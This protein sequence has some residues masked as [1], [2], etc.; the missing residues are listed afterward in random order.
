MSSKFDSD[1]EVL[2]AGS[3]SEDEVNDA[4]SSDIYK[5]NGLSIKEFTTVSQ[6]NVLT[7]N[8]QLFNETAFYLQNAMGPIVEATKFA[9]SFP[10]GASR[11]LYSKHP[12]FN[13]TIQ[14]HSEKMLSII[15]KV[16]KQIKKNIQR[17]DNDE[18]LEMML[19]CND[20][21]LERVNSHLD[22]LAGIRVNPETILIE[23]EIKGPPVVPKTLSGSWNE[24]REILTATRGHTF[25]YV[26][27]ISLS[28]I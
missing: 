3:E 13:N 16:L 17:R 26:S 23:S 19:E 10:V 27:V 20:I 7:D 21:V 15:S 11:N 5:I 28:F 18:R 4:V 8:H 12:A 14:N 2:V 6:I 22:I 25:K 24:N 9:N 1:T